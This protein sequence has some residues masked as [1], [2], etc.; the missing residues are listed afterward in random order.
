[1]P[2]K[3]GK[4]REVIGTNISKLRGE[5]YK[6]LQAVAIALDKAGVNKRKKTKATFSRKRSRKKKTKE[7]LYKKYSYP[8]PPIK[9]GKFRGVSKGVD[10]NGVYIYTHRCRSKS[11]P[12]WD[13]IPMK[14]IRWIKS[15]G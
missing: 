10:K 13:K 1:M 4:S 6:P 5:G 8:Y 3:I 2:L 15:T 14:V 12:S 7:N 11:F 9:S